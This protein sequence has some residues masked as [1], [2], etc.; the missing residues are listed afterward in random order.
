MFD[1]TLDD[2]IKKYECEEKKFV[3]INCSEIN[4]DD[5]IYILYYPYSQKYI[6]VLI[7]KFGIVREIKNEFDTQKIEHLILELN[8]Q[9]INGWHEWVSHFGNSRGYEYIIYKLI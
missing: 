9:M 1:E 6:D 8:G 3:E 4:I 2:F 5:I 7:P